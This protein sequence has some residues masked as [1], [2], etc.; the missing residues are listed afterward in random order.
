MLFLDHFQPAH[1]YLY[2][3]V[4]LA[5][6]HAH[7]TTRNAGRVNYVHTNSVVKTQY[8]YENNCTHE[9]GYAKTCVPY[10]M[11]NNT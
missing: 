9:L 11:H 2:S 8:H 1:N 4:T 5:C 10:C 7:F 3:H 6:M